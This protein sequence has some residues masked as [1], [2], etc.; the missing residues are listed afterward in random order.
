MDL[1]AGLVVHDSIPIHENGAR[2]A[3][4]AGKRHDS[5]GA[6]SSPSTVQLLAGV[7]A[8]VDARRGAVSPGGDAR[9]HFSDWMS[10]TDLETDTDSMGAACVDSDLVDFEE[11]TARSMEGSSSPSNVR[12]Q[13]GEEEEEEDEEFVEEGLGDVHGGYQTWFHGGVR[14]S[15]SGP[16]SVP[17]VGLGASHALNSRK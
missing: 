12:L 17:V 4:D 8:P 11:G 16:F 7:S 2:L 14:Q 1:T 15:V 5:E 3:M 9:S 10:D 6:E 13:E